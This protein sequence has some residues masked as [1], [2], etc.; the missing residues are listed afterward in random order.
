MR[1]ASILFT[2]AIVLALGIPAIWAAI[3][4]NEYQE[5]GIHSTLIQKGMQRYTDVIVAEG[6]IVERHLRF[7]YLRNLYIAPGFRLIHDSSLGNEVIASGPANVVDHVSSGNFAVSRQSLSF[8]RPIK[9]NEPIEVR[10]NIFEHTIGQVNL[11]FSNTNRDD[12][13]NFETRGSLQM[14]KLNISGS[15]KPLGE[16]EVEVEELQ[17]SHRNC[18][19]CGSKYPLAFTG[20]ARLVTFS[21]RKEQLDLSGLKSE[22]VQQYF[23]AMQGRKIELKDVKQLEVIYD[24]STSFD[25]NDN[26]IALRPD[27]LIVAAGTELEVKY[28]NGET[29]TEFDEAV[30]VRR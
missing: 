6:P 9:L 16:I 14:N 21:Q 29:L 8:N 10:M 26:E 4:Y 30:I 1:T 18:H 12:W 7:D 25:E 28:R 5:K 23:T 27:T 3:E 19:D 24:H 11:S 20:S 15:L 17:L 22:R 13:P 2:L